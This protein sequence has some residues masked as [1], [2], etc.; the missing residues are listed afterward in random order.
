MPDDRVLVVEDDDDL[1]ESLEILLGRRGFTVQ[2]ARHG[3]EALE[4]IDPEHPPCLIVLDLMMPVMD[5][6]E[7]RRRLL[8]DPRLASV[9]VVLCSGVADLRAAADTLEAVAY[10][11]KPVRLEKLY[12]LVA[13]HC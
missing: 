7:L 6:W 9:P 3:E 12:E 1:R 11:V 5:G 8:A 10:L 4:Q 2:S 13:S